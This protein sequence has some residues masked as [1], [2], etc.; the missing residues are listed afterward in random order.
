M[1]R[2]L[3]FTALL[4]IGCGSSDRP[5][6]APSSASTTTKTQA[7]QNASN[8]SPLGESPTEAQPKLRTM[9]LWLGAE[10]LI[11]EI[12]ASEKE[13]MTGMM[14]RT[15]MAE[16]EAML[17][18]FGG[19]RQVAFWMR[20]TLVPLSCAYIDP[21]GV[22]L[23]LHDMKPKDETPIPSATPRVQY[24][25][26]VKQGWFDRHNIKPG[27]QIRTERGTLAQTFFRGQ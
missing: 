26:E 7:V 16:N 6:A 9:K 25:L 18:I 13:V 5:G 8:T 1:A 27:T 20:N 2:A 11:T 19:P 10:E 4:G 23:E 3:V 22:I 12:A 17:F 15:Q 21:E 24:V 14:F